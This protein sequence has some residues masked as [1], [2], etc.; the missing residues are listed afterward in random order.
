MIDQPVVERARRL[1]AS[2][3]I[4][5]RTGISR[6]CR[7]RAAA[8]A[9]ASTSRAGRARARRSTTRCATIPGLANGVELWSCLIPGI[10]QRDYGS[11]AGRGA[12]DDIHGVAGAGAIDRDGA[13]AGECDA[14]LRD[15]RR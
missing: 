2:A 1:L 4:G 15:R 9:S 8:R 11:A 6:G 5:V 7:A 13:H 12:L 14:V 3:G 10:N